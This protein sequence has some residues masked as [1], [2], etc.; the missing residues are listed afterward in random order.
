MNNDTRYPS[1]QWKLLNLK[2]LAKSNPQ[3]LRDE[4]DKLRQVL[5]IT[6]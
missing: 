5:G 2:K 1:V 3:K 6:I 4:V